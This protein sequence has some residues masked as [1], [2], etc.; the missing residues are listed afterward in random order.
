MKTT[1]YMH[2]T[3]PYFL[4]PTNPVKVNLIGAGGTGSQMLTCLARMHHTL[5]QLGHPGFQVTTF[6]PDKVSDAN[7]GRQLFAESELG[8]N[9]GVALT[10]RINRFFGT[11]WRATENLF[12]W[13]PDDRLPA[14]SEANL[15]ISCVDTAQARFEIAEI[16][17]ALANRNALSRDNALYWMDCGNSRSSGQ[18]ILSTVK[19][20]R[21]PRS[22]LY[23]TVDS[24][25]QVTTEFKELLQ[26]QDESSEPS[27]SLAE[28]LEKQ[29]LFINSTI[30]T[31]GAS[32]LF[33][34]FRHAMTA[35]RGLFHN[36]DTGVTQPLSV[37][38]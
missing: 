38:A 20:I 23:I 35:K 24:L 25:P 12:A 26:S 18:V 22:E 34:L 36:M 13:T 8:M 2:F 32:L 7:L 14:H 28:A 4:E 5:R 10:N 27:C 33:S 31:M 29:D 11:D 9:K 16:L 17:Q 1:S 19:P 6:D 21:Q 30:A 37:A 3:H 15:F